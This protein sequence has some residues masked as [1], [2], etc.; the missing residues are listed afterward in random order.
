MQRV[1]LTEASEFP[2]A[3]SCDPG[4]MSGTALAA[5]AKLIANPTSAQVL[6]SLLSDRELTVSGLAGEIGA[7]RST[8]S[9]A[10]ASLADRGLVV[11]E[12]RGRVTVV[13]LAGEEV[14]EALEA[15]G[16]LTRPPAPIGFRAVTRMEALR[17]ARTC[18]DHLAGEVGVTLADRLLTAGVLTAEDATWSLASNGTE[19][20]I[21][22]GL[23]ARVFAERARRPLVRVCPD[24]TERRPHV[25]GRLGAAV[26]GFWLQ[27][28]L[29]YRLSG[30]RA[31][32]VTPAGED[33]LAR[34]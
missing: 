8:V 32:R 2:D 10:V 21:E 25:A 16:R 15:L 30:S 3:S 14:A 33:W 1:S 22:L 17:R 28:G 27:T 11:R 4:P 20:L 26:C 29:A 9:E 12:R 6:D 34:I 5:V 18:Y 24:W 7:A 31:V 19:R 13:R 23:D